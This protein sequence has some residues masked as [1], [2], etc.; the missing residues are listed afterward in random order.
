MQACGCVHERGPGATHTH[1]HTLTRP[2]PR[3]ALGRAAR[4]TLDL[5][6]KPGPAG[7][8]ARGRI[9]AKGSS[10][11]PQAGIGGQDQERRRGLP[12]TR[13][14]P[15]ARGRGRGKGCPGFLPLGRSS[16]RGRACWVPPR[17][18][19]RAG[20][21]A[22]RGRAWRGDTG[23][24]CP[25]PRP[26]RGSAPPRVRRAAAPER[27]WGAL[28]LPRLDGRVPAARLTLLGVLCFS[29]SVPARRAGGAPTLPGAGLGVRQIPLLP[30]KHPEKPAVLLRRGR[31]SSARVR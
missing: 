18:V 25:A 28:A 19:C 13:L 11:T 31:S 30:L 22:A 20:G 27:S 26:A 2:H 7:S 23:P 6:P 1:T 3:R 9:P 10:L 8:R 21:D 17:H 15:P 4:A 29:S 5:H 14:S 16:A 12:T 24:S